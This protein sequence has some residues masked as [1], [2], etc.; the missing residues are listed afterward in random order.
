MVVE[1]ALIEKRVGEVTDG[2]GGR[3]WFR[4]SEAYVPSYQTVY[5]FSST[6]K[7]VRVGTDYLQLP[8]SNGNPA[9]ICNHRGDEEVG[10][11]R[12]DSTPV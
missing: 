8:K 10:R 6:V 7:W 12:R 3:R 4:R 11:R 2:T 9:Q 5:V 1:S